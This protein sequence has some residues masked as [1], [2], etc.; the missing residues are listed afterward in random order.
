MHVHLDTV[1]GIAGDMFLAGCLDTWPELADGL[2]SVMR[3]AGLPGDWQVRLLPGHSH[4]I[5]GMR[6][7]VVGPYPEEEHLHHGDHTGVWR[8]LRTRLQAADLPNGVRARA[9]DIFGRLAAAEAA[10]HGVDIDEV[11]FHE[12]ADWDSVADIVGAA[13]CI[14][15]CGATEWSVSPLPL[16]AGTVRTAH[17]M[18]P[19]P[20]PAVARLIT[21]MA[22]VD[23]GIGGERVTPTGAAIVAHLQPQTTG[24]SGGTVVASGH[25]LGTR[26]LPDRPNLLRL[27][28]YDDTAPGTGW[29]TGTVSVLTFEIDDQSPEDLAAGLDLLRLIDGVLDV[30]QSSVHAKKGR[31]GVR[32]QVLCRPDRRDDAIRAA[33]EQTTTIG[34]RWHDEQRA[35]LVRGVVER[36]DI[37]GKTAVRPDGTITAKP[38]L[39]SIAA[40]TAS[41]AERNAARRTFDD[42]GT[43]TP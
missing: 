8:E 19:I 21:G 20:A 33:F 26:Q 31:L 42:A 38:E 5:A 16:G 27:I 1:G 39:D 6:V 12:L 37:A 17:G 40:V 9:I 3:S 30:T 29:T 41:Q 23:D 36:N 15:Q 10:V 13:W 7:A 28:A 2:E 22:V 35:E 14:E 11:H 43:E 32:V 34:L 25:G 4:G 24:P 18:L